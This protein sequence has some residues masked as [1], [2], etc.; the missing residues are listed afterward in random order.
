MIKSIFSLFGSFHLEMEIVHLSSLYHKIPLYIPYHHNRHIQ[1]NLRSVSLRNMNLDF[2][3]KSCNVANWN[4]KYLKEYSAFKPYIKKITNIF[5][6]S[7]D[8]LL[9]KTLCFHDLHSGKH[10]TQ[11]QLSRKK[12]C[13][14]KLKKKQLKT[15]TKP[16]FETI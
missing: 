8:F 9:N 7:L 16:F 10:P 14:Q 6:F 5:P 4:G 12:K 1:F 13:K 2:T 11:L 3:S 15:K